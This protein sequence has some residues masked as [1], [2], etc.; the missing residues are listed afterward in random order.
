MVSKVL[1]IKIE[2]NYKAGTSWTAK[3]SDFAQQ[4]IIDLGSVRNITQIAIQGRPHSVEYV[5]E[6]TISY[7]YNGLDYADFKE[8]GGNIKVTEA[9]EFISNVPI[10]IF[11]QS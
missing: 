3:N 11:S 9:S 10:H 2:K 5:T 6:F 4:L 7:G 8:P 1:L